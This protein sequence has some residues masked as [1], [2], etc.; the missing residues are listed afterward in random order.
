MSEE[1]VQQI[2]KEALLLVIQ[3]AGPLLLL[4]M[5]VGLI[6]AILQ[7]ASQVHEQ[8]LTF[9]PKAITIA[10]V[11]FLLSPSFMAQIQNFFHQL[12]QIIDQVSRQTI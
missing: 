2:F 11:L 12:F 5:I 3:I 8:T 9:V 7:A 4:S 10:A 1:I 6:I